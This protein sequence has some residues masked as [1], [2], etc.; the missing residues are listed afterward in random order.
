[1]LMHFKTT[2]QKSMY[3]ILKVHVRTSAIKLRILHKVILQM[4]NNS[5]Y[6]AKLVLKRRSVEGGD[7]CERTI[8]KF[9]PCHHFK[10]QLMKL[11]C[12]FE[13]SNKNIFLFNLEFS[14]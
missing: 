2:H 14:K 4:N 12:T 11:M 7:A 5:Y 1:M 10:M 9:D 3:Q 6:A 8:K 13:K